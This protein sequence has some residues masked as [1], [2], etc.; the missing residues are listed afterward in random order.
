KP[1]V[2]DGKHILVVEDEAD[3]AHLVEV[4]L[5]LAGHRVSIARDGAEGL[6]RA[7]QEHPDLILLDVMM[8]VLDGW[9]VLRS[10]KEDD[11]LQDIPVVMLT[12][13]SEERDLIRGHLQGAVRYLTKPFEM[14]MLLQTVEDG[15]R[16]PDDAE[17]QERRTKVRLLLQRLAEL[18]SGRAGEHGVRFSKL[19]SP[20]EVRSAP[21]APSV[22]DRSKLD[23]L[24]GKQ[25]YVAAQL[26]AGRS[27]RDL[28]EELDVSRSNIYATRK[29]IARKLGVHPDHVADE[30]K[31]LGLART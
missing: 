22:A 31:R 18:D 12:A 16:V 24:T 21:A 2:A 14:R 26:A 11:G 5:D 15:L 28:A 30:A 19:E 23:L 8:P 17:L 13:L 25:R 27:A 6:T 29:R 10:L 4:N 20:R 9:Q 7:R 1:H 3:L